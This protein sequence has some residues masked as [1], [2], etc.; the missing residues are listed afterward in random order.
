MFA[1]DLPAGPLSRQG[2]DKFSDTSIFDIAIDDINS[3]DDRAVFV[4]VNN[5]YVFFYAN[6]MLKLRCRNII[7]DTYIYYNDLMSNEGTK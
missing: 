3:S 2:L 4:R 5:I 1:V 6:N 7:S